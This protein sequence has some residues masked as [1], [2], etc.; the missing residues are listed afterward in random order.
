MNNEIY[1]DDPS[2]ITLKELFDHFIGV[3]EDGDQKAVVETSLISLEKDVPEEVTHFTSLDAVLNFLS[4]VGD[5]VTIELDYGKE[6][7]I[8]L[9]RMLEVTREYLKTLDKSKSLLMYTITD[10][11]NETNYSVS[12]CCPVACVQGYS[13]EN[14]SMTAVQ[15]IFSIEYMFI[16]KNDLD[17]EKIRAEIIRGI[18]AEERA[19]EQDQEEDIDDSKTAG[20]DMGVEVPWEDNLLSGIR[21]TED[22]L[23]NNKDV[24]FTDENDPFLQ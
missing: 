17:I 20:E 11:L 7:N 8:W 6:N 2:E 12:F 13:K 18:E 24:R 3:D 16:A 5:F 1:N 19:D 9:N 14:D 22:E 4:V 21:S 23:T 15:L 10:L